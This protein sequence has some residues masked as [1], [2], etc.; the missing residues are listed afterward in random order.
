MSLKPEQKACRKC[1][2]D[3]KETFVWLSSGFGKSIRLQDNSLVVAV[4]RYLSA[5]LSWQNA[6][7]AM[8]C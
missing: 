2:F 6:R 1:V 3:G 7:V 8:C 5:S 4:H